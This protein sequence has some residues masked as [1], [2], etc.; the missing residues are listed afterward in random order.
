MCRIL[1][2]FTLFIL[3]LFAFF[4]MPGTLWAARYHVTDVW[5]YVYKWQ[6]SEITGLFHDSSGNLYTVD[7]ELCLVN[8]YNSSG[9]LLLR[10]GWCGTGTGQFSYPSGV[11]VDS[12][13]YIYVSDTYNFRIQKFDSQGHF[14]QSWPLPQNAGGQDGRPYD[15]DIDAANNIYV[16]VDILSKVYK[17]SPNGLLLGIFGSGYGSGPG[18]MLSPRGVCVA[19]NGDVYVSDSTTYG[20]I[21]R[22]DKDGT[23]I[24]RLGDD[25]TQPGYIGM[26]SPNGM[27]LMGNSVVVTLSG[28]L[29]RYTFNGTFIES[30]GE[31][32]FEGHQFWN[33][34]DVSVG[35]AGTVAVGS[36]QPW[37]Q[38]FTT[39]PWTFVA[40]WSS[41]SNAA[42][43]FDG[44]SDFAIGFQ[45]VVY[46]A[47]SG[48]D[49]IQMFT[50]EGSYLKSWGS[51]GTAYGQFNLPYSLDVDDQGNVYVSD[52]WNYRIQKFDADGNFIKAWGSKGS[53]YTQFEGVVRLR[54]GPDGNLYTLDRYNHRVQIFTKNGDF[55]NMWGTPGNKE[56]E[57]TWPE[58]LAIDKLG[59]L[60]ISDD[61]KR[62]QK[63]TAQGLFVAQFGGEY[64]DP[65]FERIEDMT[66]DTDGNLLALNFN[67]QKVLSVDPVNGEVLS[68]FGRKGIEPGMFFWAT[69]L[70]VAPDKGLF[71]G[72]GGSNRVQVFQEANG[73]D[74]SAVKLLLL[75]E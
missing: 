4:F 47:D 13:G 2:Y 1:R 29:Y 75:L 34:N 8:K 22:F 73:V 19:S 71:I 65:T 54:F 52:Y 18:Q 67:L 12:F 53:G 61:Y 5:D 62:I 28:V 45:G 56:G 27:S 23:F 14:V 11:A 36:R 42:G 55:V 24:S 44:P 37:V 63:F 48:N 64:Q 6:F 15:I 46:V 21:L 69:T 33:L 40:A 60:Y 68:S 25:D 43:Y 10:F 70:R 26:G 74:L 51:E 66:F 38:L 72:E 32:G 39:S 57:L 35:P 50:K 3:D 16:A 20:S 30:L 41:A 49:R 17:Y 7:E 31:S 58:S 9:D 59:H